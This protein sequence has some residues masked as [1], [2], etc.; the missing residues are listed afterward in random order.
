M[1]RMSA[2]EVAPRPVVSRTIRAVPGRPGSTDP[3]VAGD[4]PHRRPLSWGLVGE[5]R[6]EL[7]PEPDRTGRPAGVQRY[8][9]LDALRGL[10]MVLGVVLHAALVYSTRAAWVVSDPR[11]SSAFDAVY[12]AIHLF[13]LP[14]FFL[15]SGLLC[16]G[17]LS[18]GARPF[19]SSR[20]VRLAVPLITTAVLINPLQV[21]LTDGPAEFWEAFTGGRWVGHLWFLIDLLAYTVLVAAVRALWPWVLAWRPPD[22]GGAVV[23]VVPLASAGLRWACDRFPSEDA[24]LDPRDLL[25]HLPFFAFG[26]W[27]LRDR[28]GAQLRRLAWWAVPVLLFAVT[29]PLDHV[30][31]VGLYADAAAA[32]AASLLVLAAGRALLDRPWRLARGLAEASY[33]IYLLHQ[34]VVVALALL[35]LPTGVPN[36]VKFAAVVAGGLLGP[37][38]VHVYLVRPTPALRFLLN[39]HRRRPSTGVP[40]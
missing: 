35:L 40:A 33:T 32:W 15:I 21:L 1:T 34:V 6:P 38:A 7:D 26:L 10:L 22:L 18:A 37:L 20:V 8:H 2:T 11:R 25:Y 14:T 23:L 39:G 4:D 31:G 28:D 12:D 30:R 29:G 36:G 19:L 9:D 24:A 5:T 27:Y 16:A 13:R 3:H 17:G